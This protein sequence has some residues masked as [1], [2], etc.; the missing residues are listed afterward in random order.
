MKVPTIRSLSRHGSAPSYALAYLASLFT[1]AA[2]LTLH[3][4][5]KLPPARFWSEFGLGVCLIGYAAFI[6]YAP[7]KDLELNQSAE[8]RLARLNAKTD[9]ELEKEGGSAPGSPARKPETVTDN[10]ESENE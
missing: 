2:A 10:S 9:A 4:A 1:T 3:L 6:A 5:S 7:V 8:E